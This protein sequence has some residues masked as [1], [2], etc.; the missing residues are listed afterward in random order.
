M[1]EAFEKLSYYL[2]NFAFVRY[3]LIVG[4]LVALC[5]AV[6]GVSL[7][8]KNFSMIGDGLSHVAF[9][10]LAIAAVAGLTE[11][12]FVILPVTMAVAMFLLQ[13]KDRK[14]IKGDALIAMLSVGALAIGYLLL[15]RF[16][17]SAN[18]SGDVCTSL[19]G[20]TAIL[21][22]S[23]S[24]V[25]ICIGLSIFVLLFFLLFYHRIFAVTFDENFVRAT[26]KGTFFFNLAFAALIAIVVVI[27][28]KFVGSLLVSALIVFP[29]LSAMR[30]FRSFKLVTIASA[31]ISVLASFLG[32]ILSIMIDTPIGP[33][34]ILID[35]LFFLICFLVGAISRKAKV[36]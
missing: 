4:I 35:L 6:L 25:W 22:L 34:I 3:A 18:V 14:K 29:A 13:A 7:V 12:T 27:A 8:L 36:A 31:I 30:L 26:E 33:T 10:A 24:D 11:N 5:A 9:G 17:K 1:I 20:S 28:M 15:N 32:I 23:M 19:F 21:T 2:T 16:S